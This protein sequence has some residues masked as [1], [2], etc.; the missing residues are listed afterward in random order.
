[1]VP[2]PPGR[3]FTSRAP[4]DDARARRA[5]LAARA[6]P[7][8]PGRAGRFGVSGAITVTL[9][10]ACLVYGRSSAA[11]TTDGVSHWGDARVVAS[12]TAAVILLGAFV[13]IE[14]RSRL[15]LVPLRIF[16]NLRCSGAYLV[17]LCLGTARFG[18]F[19]FLTLFRKTSEGT[20]RRAPG[21]PTCPWSP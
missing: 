9:G 13:V 6:L 17:M 18:L 4:S 7:E 19:F 14:T 15:A 12:L 10:L 1:L 5:L 11:M 2:G 21:W 16:R 3:N 8:V 20:A